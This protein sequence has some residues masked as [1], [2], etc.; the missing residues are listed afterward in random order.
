MQPGL[1]GEFYDNSHVVAIVGR[2]VGRR[3]FDSN[4][5]KPLPLS[6]DSLDACCLGPTTFHVSYAMRFVPSKKLL[7]AAQARAREAGAAK[8]RRRSDACGREE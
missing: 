3:I 2:D 5:H 8:V 6:R 1:D 7:R 4:Q